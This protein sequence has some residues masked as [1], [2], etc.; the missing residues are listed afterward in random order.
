MEDNISKRKGDIIGLWVLG[1]LLA[2]Q[3]VRVFLIVYS[4]RYDI[5]GNEL[6]TPYLKAFAYSLYLYPSVFIVAFGGL[7]YY[8]FCP[9]TKKPYLRGRPV[10]VKIFGS[11][12]GFLH[13]A[14]LLLF[15]VFSFFISGLDSE[16][17]IIGWLFFMIIGIPI[18]L[19]CYFL[20]RKR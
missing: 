5:D 19:I 8:L 3:I 1:I 9:I 18:D 12:F 10:I 17:I 6:P 14:V 7:I 16:G 4:E 15:C 11:I 2:V 20:W 13:L